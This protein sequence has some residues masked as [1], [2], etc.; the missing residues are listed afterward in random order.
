MDILSEINTTESTQ[1]NEFSVTKLDG[2][3]VIGEKHLRENP[4]TKEDQRFKQI[5]EK[6][7]ESIFVLESKP[8]QSSVFSNSGNTFMSQTLKFGQENNNRMEIMDDER[9][10]KDR[11]GIWKEAGSD[12]TIEDFD[13]INSLYL[14]RQGLAIYNLSFEQIVSNVMNS[15]ILDNSRKETYL[16]GFLRYTR[17]IQGENR[18]ENLQKIDKLLSSF[19]NYDSICREIYYQ[20]KIDKI[21][22]EN[23]NKNILA[24]FGQSHF[25]GIAKTIQNNEYRT[26]LPSGAKIRWEMNI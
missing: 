4:S 18:K 24:V 15:E 11:Y 6:N 16:N 8:S 3:T 20:G 22:K 12:L 23:P 2:T 17:Y 21:V 26:P 5:L 25:Q 9:I 7:K 19:I 13:S 10:S 1:E 14:M